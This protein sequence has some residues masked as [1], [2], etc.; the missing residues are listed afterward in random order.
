LRWKGWG[1]LIQTTGKGTLALWVSTI[2]W[3]ILCGCHFNKK[4]P[5]LQVDMSCLV[6][7]INWRILCGCHFNK[8][9]LGCRWTCP[10]WF[11]PSNGAYCV[12]VTL[13]KR[14]LVAGGHVLP[15]VYHQLVPRNG[16][17]H[18][19]INKGNPC[20]CRRLNKLH[21]K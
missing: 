13:I 7:T 2:N 8:K 9:T 10:A 12:V 19:D 3:S 14:P 6:S 15:G 16:E 20:L 11:L 1:E 21:V 18:G 5:C 4:D 17:W